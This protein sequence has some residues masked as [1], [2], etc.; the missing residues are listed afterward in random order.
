MKRIFAIIGLLVLLTGC[1]ASA[2]FQASDGSKLPVQAQLFLQPQP[3]PTVVIAHGSAGLTP[4]DGNW[5]LTARSWG[6]NAVAVDHYTLRGISRHT[7]ELVAG[8]EPQTRAQDLV[9]VANW[10]KQQPW[11]R[12]KIAVIGFSQGGAGVFSLISDESPYA[13]AVTF[14]P[15]CGKMP[16]PTNPKIPT[17]VHLAQADNLSFIRRCIP[18]LGHSLYDVH[19]HENATHAFDVPYVP[20]TRFTHRHDA[21]AVERATQQIKKFFALHL[22]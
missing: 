1:A 20:T 16:P 12:G 8:A 17:Q 14:Y 18:T 19:M 11:H 2:N 21:N 22:E 5:A 10:I 7:G 6:Y 15:A 13:V 9:A 3:A 4:S